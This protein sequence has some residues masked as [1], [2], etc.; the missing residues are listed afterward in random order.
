MC[1]RAIFQNI[2]PGS[3]ITLKATYALQRTCLGE[4]NLLIVN[5]IRLIAG[6]NGRG[7]DQYRCT[8]ATLR[9]AQ[10]RICAASQ[11]TFARLMSDRRLLLTCR[12]TLVYPQNQRL[13]N[14]NRRYA[15]HHRSSLINL[16]TFCICIPII[17]HKDC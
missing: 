1:D 15:F 10:S 8:Y 4:D 13:Y 17:R 7:N 3:N 2:K 12:G 9:N 14:I 11:K 16:L 5:N 6:N